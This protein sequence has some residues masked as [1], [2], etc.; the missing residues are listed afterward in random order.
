VEQVRRAEATLILAGD[1]KQLPPILAGAP[2]E[3]IANEVGATALQEN[4]RQADPADRRAVELLRKGDVAL[5]IQQYAERDRVTVGTGLRDTLQKLAASWSENGGCRRP[6]EHMIFTQTRAEAREVNRL[7]QKRLLQSL[8]AVPLLSVRHGQ[9]KYHLGDRILFH[10]ASRWQG[11]ENGYPGTVIA[12][13]PILRRLTVKLDQEPSAAAKA[14]GASRFVRVPLRQLSPEAISL[15]YAATT[16][17][18][19]GQTVRHAYLLMSG[20]MV[21]REMAYVQ[22]TRAKQTTRIFVDQLDAGPE[23]TDLIKA[24][25]R[26]KAKNMA[27]DLAFPLPPPARSVSQSPRIER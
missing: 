20:D 17:K 15:G 8:R 2:M 27:H 16:H 23:L 7:C 9:D 1:W 3:R 13:D 26:T 19:Q 18:M 5:A 24:V 6:A 12:V 22:A 4:R 25:E 10:Q 11:I 21:S 14:K